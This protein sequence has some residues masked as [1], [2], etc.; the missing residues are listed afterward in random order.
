M[1]KICTEIVQHRGVVRG[2]Q[3]H[4]VRDLPHRFQAR[5]ADRQGVR[6]YEKGRFVSVYYDAN[7]ATMRQ[8]EQ[9]LTLDEEVLRHTNLR[10]RSIVDFVNISDESKNP[11]VKQAQR[12]RSSKERRTRQPSSEATSSEPPLEPRPSDQM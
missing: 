2:I 12:E 8:V 4:G 10:A 9:I 5:Y 6:Y 7:P 3:N 11:Y 1:K